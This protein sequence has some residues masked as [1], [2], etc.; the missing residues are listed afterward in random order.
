MYHIFSI[1]SSIDG[2]LGCF[3]VWAIVKSVA[4]NVAHI[5]LNYGFL[6]IYAQEC[7]CWITWY[8]YL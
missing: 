7:D 1:R 6:Q 8:F 4:M 5:F 2:R 3:H